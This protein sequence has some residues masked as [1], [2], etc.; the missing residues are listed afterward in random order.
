MHGPV[1]VKFRSGHVP[2]YVYS[3]FT[4]CCVIRTTVMFREHPYI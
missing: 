1:N 3:C 2:E 4:K